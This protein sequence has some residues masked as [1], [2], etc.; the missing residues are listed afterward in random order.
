V[1]LFPSIGSHEWEVGMN[2][3]LVRGLLA[4]AT[5]AGAGWVI[6]RRTALG[7]AAAGLTQRVERDL[8]YARAAVPGLAYRLSGRHPAVD[9]DDTT[10]AD[11]VRST[12]GPVEK[13]LDLPRVHVLVEQRVARLDGDVARASDA[14]RIERAV[15]AVSGI[16]DVDSHLHIGLVGGDTR[17]SEAPGPAPSEQ[18]R[19]LRAAASAAGAVD[20]DVAV[21]A[22]VR[23]FLA[24]LPEGERAHV[25]THIPQDLRDLVM[26]PLSLDHPVHEAR[27]LEQFCGAVADSA[28]QDRDR[29][30]A[31]VPAVLS[32]LRTSIPEEA[33]DVAATLPP[34]LRDAWTADL[35]GTA[36]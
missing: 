32:E 2:R 1:G 22:V 20:D 12:L 31:I 5:L 29:L 36:S 11:R 30:D 27:T 14:D 15:R 6:I 25:W 16:A 18:H 13:A 33:S 17:P 9:V 7:D 23:G 26:P 28:P 3:R 8:R 4:G 10:L 34:E 24:R 21:R 19:R 35:A